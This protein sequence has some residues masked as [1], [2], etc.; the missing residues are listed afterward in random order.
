MSTKCLDK[1]TLGYEQ[2]EIV[3]NSICLESKIEENGDCKEEI[4]TRLIL[5]SATMRG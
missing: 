2:I 3:K 1:F 4:Q 5:G